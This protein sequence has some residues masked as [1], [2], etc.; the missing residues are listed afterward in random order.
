[1][2]GI[3][4][5]KG[6]CLFLATKVTRN[7]ISST[8]TM[9][10]DTLASIAEKCGCS[11][12][13]VSRVMSGKA[14]KY[15]ISETTKNLILRE[16]QKSNYTPSLI[17]KGLRAGKTDTIGLLI[18]GIDDVFF[19]SIASIIISEAKQ[20]N[21]NVV[22]V[23]TQENEKN[24]EDG[25]M[26]LLARNVDGVI[27]VPCAD[28]SNLYSKITDK[29][30]PLVIVD[31]YFSDSR[32]TSFVTTDNYSGACMAVEYLI[33]NG[34]K[35]IACLQGNNE[36][37]TS[38]NRVQG[39]I[40]TMK[41]H[42]LDK[43]ISVN[44]EEFSIRNGYIESQLILNRKERPT[45]LFALSNKIILGCVKAVHEAGLRVPE[46]IS[47]IAFDDNLLYNYLTPNMTCIAQP[48][49]EISLMAINMLLKI[50]NGDKGTSR[51][52]LPPSLIVRNSVKKI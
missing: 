37:M 35:N 46:D 34:H 25:L 41:K 27:A 32:D 16:A 28:N 8:K 7:G 49:Q 52:F 13:T 11:V 10:V 26:N 21:Y 36:A 19:S 12:S 24:E 43:Y 29:E 23:D 40:D 30:I 38:R 5:F 22:V 31:R 33:S 9:A 2:P 3:S 1:M 4:L 14:A 18:P 47:L 39:Y 48:V 15:R 51:V 17:A 42:G 44:G 20:R 45:A 6:I 50:M